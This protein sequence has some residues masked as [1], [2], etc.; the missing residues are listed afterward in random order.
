MFD[1]VRRGD[2]H[3][4]MAALVGFACAAAHRYQGQPPAFDVRWLGASLLF[5]FA[6]PLATAWLLLGT[7]ARNLGLTLG[8]WR[9]GLQSFLAAA[10][11]TTPV[12]WLASRNPNVQA[13]YPQVHTDHFWPWATFMLIDYFALEFLWRG[14]FQI[15]LGDRIGPLNAL[16]IQVGAACLVHWNKPEAE[17]LA[18]I[19]TGTYFGLLSWRTRSMVW[20]M[21]IHAWM[22]ILIEYLC[23]PT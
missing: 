6:I 12:I 18:S 17:T 15:G 7:R 13:Q 22:G 16:M 8:E 19:V 14:Y 20:P 4:L 23:S 1:P 3:V 5:Y 21:L 11:V 2:R 9:F 10:A